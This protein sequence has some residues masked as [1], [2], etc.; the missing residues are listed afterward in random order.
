[1]KLFIAGVFFCAS[2]CA[3][4]QQ[5]QMLNIEL[6]HFI[7]SASS[8]TPVDLYLRGNQT[9][10]QSFVRTHNGK[11]KLAKG[12]ILSCT[13]MAGDLEELN[14]LEGL[15]Y[16]EFSNARPQLLNDVMITNNNIHP[17]HAGASPLPEAYRGE[18]VIMGF[19]D[20][21]LDLAHPDF[22]NPDGST[23]I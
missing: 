8:S 19:I 12:E 20:T 13:L 22:H 23:R 18:D 3:N 2:L 1:M 17:I 7:K 4:A 5:H 9:A 10:M 14:N 21:G 15:A 11:I 16:V 6:Q